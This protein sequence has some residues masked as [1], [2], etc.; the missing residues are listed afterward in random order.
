MLISAGVPAK[1]IVDRWSLDTLH[2][3]FTG[4]PGGVPSSPPAPA[5]PG[6]RPL[7]P[8]PNSGA[9]AIAA[10]AAQGGAAPAGCA[11]AAQSGA[12]QQ[13]QKPFA[14]P[15]WEA[16]TLPQPRAPP[17]APAASHQLPAPADQN[18]PAAPPPLAPAAARQ[19]PVPQRAGSGGV[20]AG[21]RSP[22]AQQQQQQQAAAAPSGLP[23]PLSTSQG[24]GAAVMRIGSASGGRDAPA[25]LSTLGAII[26]APNLARPALAQ[27]Q[28]PPSPA[29]APAAA[30]HVASAA[31]DAPA[32]VADGAV[33]VVLSQQ[34]PGSVRLVRAGG[35]DAT[36]ASGCAMPLK[37]RNSA[38]APLVDTPPCARLENALPKGA[39]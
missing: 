10:S 39:G 18:A 36:S 23:T 25:W 4:P 37:S 22:A 38:D 9:A 15:W 20:P 29:P 24:A 3:F 8:A 32:P 17:L 14:A 2:R 34:Q 27:Q 33:R 35:G 1:A 5:A 16:A 13:Q 6:A 7:L 12:H 21:R 11:Q 28:Q 19:L 30:A 31:A 26:K